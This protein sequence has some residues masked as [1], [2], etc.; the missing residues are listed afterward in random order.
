MTFGELVSLGAVLCLLAGGC[1]AGGE[2]RQ[3]FGLADRAAWQIDGDFTDEF[4]AAGLDPAKWWDRNPEWNGREPGWFSPKNVTISGGQLHITM[5]KED[6]PDLPK[7]YH[8]LT[9]A[10]VKSKAPVLYGYFEIKARPMR[11]RG[12]SS[13]FFYNSTPTLW[14]E[15]DVFEM[16]A[17]KPGEE[18]KDHMN[19]H[20]FTTPEAPGKH[21]D[22]PTT[23]DS[24]VAFAD[25]WHVYGLLWTKDA[26]AWYVDGVERRRQE[27]THWHQP[28]FLCLDSETMGDWFGLPEAKDLPSTFSIEYVR[29]WKRRD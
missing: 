22:K 17:G 1:A 7:G 11:S 20:V 23:W 25:D 14:T 9:S 2:A 12:S 6:L 8:T 3:P 26:L 21:W 28:L 4:N 19:V 18:R 29:A 16:G 24:P 27:N 10:F 13:F 15:I 5:R